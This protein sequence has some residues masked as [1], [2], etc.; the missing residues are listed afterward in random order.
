MSEARWDGQAWP[1][2]R[3]LR[4]GCQAGQGQEIKAASAPR[5][6]VG[7]GGGPQ[8][9]LA[10]RIQ[11]G[12]GEGRAARARRA[13]RESARQVWRDDTLHRW[14]RTR[15]GT[16]LKARQEAGGPQPSGRAGLGA[17][18][19]G[20]GSHRRLSQGGWTEVPRGPPRA[21]A[22][23]RPGLRGLPGPCAP[24]ARE[25]GQRMPRA[26]SRAP[27]VLAAA[28]RGPN[29]GESEGPGAGPTV[30]RPQGPRVLRPT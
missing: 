4:R 13:G 19:T 6:A 10:R 30:G 29:P 9:P 25:E 14:P 23:G 8:S 24:L 12:G 21:P 1:G 22:H 26:R 7:G 18:P 17:G 27:A 11:A 2:L 3:L 28:A 5:A 20:R 16:D 15:L